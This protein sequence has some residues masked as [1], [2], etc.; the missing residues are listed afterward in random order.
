MSCGAENEANDLLTALLEGKDFDIP[1]V[2]LGDIKLPNTNQIGAEIKK[3][4]VADLT[5][6][7]VGGTGVFDQLLATMRAHLKEEF[8]K[9]R[10][11]GPEY[12]K[13]YVQMFAACLQSAN[14]FLLGKDQAFWA[15]QTAQIQAI[16]ATVGIETAK[17]QYAQTQLEAQGAAANFGLTKIKLANESA[18]YCLQQDE[19]NNLRPQQL[20][21][22]QEQQRLIKEQME[23]ARAQT[24]STRTDGSVVA[25][26]MG[27]QQDLYTQQITSYKRDSELKTVKVFT[28]AWVAQKTVDEGLAPPT[29]FA[30]ANLDIMLN[31]L[32]IN[33][34][35]A[36]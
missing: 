2:D 11:T 27:K 1:V 22:L 28:D 23:S 7:M 12:T 24:L 34:E 9:N 10:I 31:R 15:A 21:N 30:N 20:L 5:T 14:Q 13:A 17:V 32:Q 29:K 3:V 36:A 33:N 4:T 26:S 19:L 8:E 35:L 18:T 6:K 25:G 16:T